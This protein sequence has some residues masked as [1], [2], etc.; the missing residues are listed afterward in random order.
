MVIPVNVAKILNKC[1]VEFGILGAEESCCGNEIRRMERRAFLK[2]FRKETPLFSKIRGEGNH[3]LV[4]SLHERSQEGIRDPGIPVVHYTEV[5]SE[6][7]TAG[8][9]PSRRPTTRRS[10][11]MTHVFSVSRTRFSMRPGTSSRPYRSRIPGVHL[12]KR[13]L[14]VL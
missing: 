3:R 12:F 13:E 2:T 8:T 14:S 6:L 9:L 11:T 7:V 5:I 10:F 4:P 1:G